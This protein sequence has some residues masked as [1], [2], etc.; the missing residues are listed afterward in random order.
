MRNIFVILKKEIR[1]TIR[2]RRTLLVMVVIPLVLFPLLINIATKMAVSEQ[3][4]ASERVL[5]VGLITHGNAAPF[6][7]K[8]MEEELITVIEDLG[9]NRIDQELR[10]E[11]VDFFLVFEREFDRR[12]A[13]MERGRIDLHFISSRETGTTKRRITGLLRTFEEEQIGLRL[14]DLNLE[15]GIIDVFGLEEHDHASMKQRIGEAIGGF[16]PYIFVI[17]CFV[18]AMYPAIDLAAGEK[19]RG[20]IETLLASPATRLEIVLGKFTVVFLSGIGTALISVIGLYLSVRSSQDIPEE[21]LGSLLKVVSA[22]SVLLVFSLLIPLAVFFAAVLLS[23]SIFAHSFKEAQSIMTPLNILVIFPV[24]IGLFPG[25]E[26]NAMTA[27]VPVLN[28]SLA[29]REI[30]SGTISTGMLLMV[31][32][33]LFVLAGLSLWF[34]A[35]WFRRESVVF[36]RG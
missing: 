36:R 24:F 15:R 27:I 10:E 30:I 8:L 25:V 33:S 6:R 34:C 5:K 9:E 21:L 16:I 28:V 19:E 13:A 3:K 2:D 14:A 18:G 7:Q 23:I 1:D 17:F 11:T 35:A 12:L 4:R 32:L 20:T 29:T 31:Y 26:L 22:Q